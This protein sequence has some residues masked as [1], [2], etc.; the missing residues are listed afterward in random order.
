MTLIGINCNGLNSKWQSFNKIIHDLKP[1]VFFLQETKL[2]HKQQ[3]KSDTSEY[4]IF[5][6]ERE[7]SGGGGIALG[8][9][10]DLNPI[11]IRMGNDATEAISVK[12][13][14]NKFEVRL[15]VGY[16]AQENDRQAKLHEMSTDERKMLLWEFLDIEINE[17]QTME[18]GLIIQLDANAHL[19]LDFIKGDP[20]PRN[21]NGTL[22][23]EFLERNPAITVVNSLKLCKGLITRR[24]ETIKGVEEAVLDFFLVNE[25]MLQYLTNMT[26]DEEEK[27]AL[28]NIAQKKKSKYAK[29][30][31]HRTLIMNLNIQFNKI[32]PD[33]KE[34]FNFKSEACQSVFKNITDHE[35]KLIEC[36]QT[37]GT[38][39]EKARNWQKHL[40][41]IFYNSFTKIRVKNSNKKSN[42]KESKLF[43]ERTTLLRKIARKENDDACNRILE[44]EEQLCEANFK[45][46][47][48]HVK[49]QLNF[50]L[51]NDSTNGTRS[52]W[53]I[54]RKVRPRH[55]PVI[56]VGKKNQL[57]TIATNHMEL[58]KLY[59]ET[60]VWR[61]RERPSHPNL[62]EIHSAKQKMFET[63]L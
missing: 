41:T 33:I 25:K 5:R 23:Y 1:C 50:A 9:T 56:P 48:T 46:K 54:Y 62:V 34:M 15:V 26:V 6:L 18:Q 16:G 32:K 20:N 61:L 51:K 35:T 39:D 11:L 49:D 14:I 7:K 52:V 43:D 29:K 28:I 38:L 21:S 40:E 45:N 3:F 42:S 36:L 24:R 2:P 12:I 19:G 27:F 57:G 13:N 30:S 22:T 8:V 60:Y 17:S 47:S 59:L 4:C 10:Q 55:K 63:V 44:I 53:T 58:K 31:D 37:E